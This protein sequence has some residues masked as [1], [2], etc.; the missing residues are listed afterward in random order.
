QGGKTEV[1]ELMSSLSQKIQSI[2]SLQYLQGRREKIEK[3]IKQNNQAIGVHILNASEFKTLYNEFTTDLL[4]FHQYDPLL[5]GKNSL[6]HCQTVA[7][8]EIDENNTFMVDFHIKSLLDITPIQERKGTTQSNLINPMIWSLQVMGLMELLKR[9]YP[10]ENKPDNFISKEELKVIEKVLKLGEET[11]LFSIS[12]R[13]PILFQS[14]LER[15]YQAGKSVKNALAEFIKEEELT[16]TKER[17]KLFSDYMQYPELRDDKLATREYA[18]SMLDVFKEQKININF[19]VKP[20][21]FTGEF[22][23]YHCK[24][25]GGKIVSYYFD[26]T[27]SSAKPYVDLY[28]KE[29]H[30]SIT[31]IMTTYIEKIKTFQG[32]PIGVFKYFSLPMITPHQYYLFALPRKAGDPILP[33]PEHYKTNIHNLL[34]VAEWVGIGH[35]KY[36]YR[37]AEREEKKCDFILETH[38]ETA[39]ESHLIS[40]LKTPYNPGIYTDPKYRAEAIW[41]YWVG[42]DYCKNEKDYLYNTPYQQTSH[43]QNT[44]KRHIHEPISKIYPGRYSEIKKENG[45]ILHAEEKIIVNDQS[46]FTTNILRQ[47]KQE[48]NKYKSI[49]FNKIKQ[50]I[51]SNEESVLGKALVEYSYTFYMLKSALYIA[52]GEDN[53]NDHEGFHHII[54]KTGFNSRH[55]ILSILDS[56]IEKDIAIDKCIEAHVTLI[57]EE[58]SA[59]VSHISNVREDLLKPTTQQFILNTLTTLV[60]WYKPRAI[61]ENQVYSKISYEAMQE[62][63]LKT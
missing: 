32:K 23:N 52:Y 26:A 34:Q 28:V 18:T 47:I 1:R 62:E 45:N 39:S 63:Q 16:I 14:L 5:V 38:Y 22:S 6:T 61:D 42:G 21:W 54:N 20:Y 2:H 3:I 8:Y 15:Y 56:L 27:S 33:L 57:K 4:T 40:S 43:E 50:T 11:N 35:I 58:V 59:A 48:Q 24:F 49:L 7:E 25:P 36:H 13:D 37:L 51:V 12:L 31:S 55:E 46:E 9:F 41:W 17:N 29:R 10:N 44:E 53:L 19:Q 30:K 60:N